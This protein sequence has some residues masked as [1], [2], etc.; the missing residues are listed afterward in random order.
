MRP[1]ATGDSMGRLAEWERFSLS[2]R[3]RAYG[4]LSA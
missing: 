3:R 1:Y 4:I 2:A